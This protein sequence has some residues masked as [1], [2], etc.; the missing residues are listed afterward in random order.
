[1]LRLTLDLGTPS[2]RAADAKLLVAATFSKA[3]KVVQ[4]DHGLI[5]PLMAWSVYDGPDAFSPANPYVASSPTT[6]KAILAVQRGP[7]DQGR[8]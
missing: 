6:R 7:E 8:D 1:M 3:R 2:A 5:V 4:V